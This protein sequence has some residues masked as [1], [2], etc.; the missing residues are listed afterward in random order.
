MSATPAA[1]VAKPA[2]PEAVA[3]SHKDAV[4]DAAPAACFPVDFAPIVRAAKVAAR[5]KLAA[6]PPWPNTPILTTPFAARVTSLSTTRRQSAHKTS[7][8]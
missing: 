5:N 6:V 1:T 3:A 2:A 7:S 8:G 4:A